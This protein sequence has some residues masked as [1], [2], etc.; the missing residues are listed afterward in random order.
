MALVVLVSDGLEDLA[1]LDRPILAKAF[2]GELVEQ[3]PSDEPVSVLLERIR[4]GREAGPAKAERGCKGA[5]A[6]A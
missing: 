5:K 3:D 4:Q 6:E 2:R 1:Q